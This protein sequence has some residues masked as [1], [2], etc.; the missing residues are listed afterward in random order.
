M[1]DSVRAPVFYWAD[2][3]I[4][5]V[6]DRRLAQAQSVAQIACI[7]GVSDASIKG[8]LHRAR[9]CAK[10]GSRMAGLV[11]EYERRKAAGNM[12]YKGGDK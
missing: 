3:D 9:H 8:L 12:I 4:L 1:T 5:D 11:A 2:G 6:L 10:P 7:F